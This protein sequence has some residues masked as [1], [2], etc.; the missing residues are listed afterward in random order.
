MVE[1]DKNIRMRNYQTMAITIAT[2]IMMPMGLTMFGY[3]DTY[4]QEENNNKY[5]SGAWEDALEY[6]QTSN[7]EGS[8]YPLSQQRKANSEIVATCLPAGTGLMPP[9]STPSGYNSTMPPS[10]YRFL[11]NK[12]CFDGIEKEDIDKLTMADII[13]KICWF[14]DYQ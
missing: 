1:G 9:D 11:E 3:K 5:I 14:N 13:T 2:I 4:S 10:L 8:K 6:N 12:G 7:F